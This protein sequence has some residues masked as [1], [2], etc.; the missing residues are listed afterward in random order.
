MEQHKDLVVRWTQTLTEFKA[1][2]DAEFSMYSVAL[3]ELLD[4][5]QSTVHAS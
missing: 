5:A 2:E 1:T 4:L 3:R